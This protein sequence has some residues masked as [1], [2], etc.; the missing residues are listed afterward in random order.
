MTY[1]KST[2]TEAATGRYEEIEVTPEMVGRGVDVLR[3]LLHAR[4]EFSDFDLEAMV[5]GVLRG[6]LGA[7]NDSSEK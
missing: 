3:E 2:D 7:N 6:A 4:P 5:E 1:L